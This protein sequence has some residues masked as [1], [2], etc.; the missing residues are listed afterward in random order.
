M[1]AELSI[2]EK[3]TLLALARQALEAAANGRP[4]PAP[5]AQ[6][7]PPALREPASSFVTLMRAGQLRGCIGGLTPEEPLWA[8]V[9]RHAAAAGLDDYRFGPV[10]PAEVPLIEIEVSV[11][12]P[13]QPL[14]YASPAELVSR[15]RPGVDG[16]VLMDGHRRATF[17]PQVWEHVPN[18]ETFL[19]LLCEKLGA[20][21][22][23]WRRGGLKVETYQV[24]KFTESEMKVET[25][26]GQPPARP[27]N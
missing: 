26:L 12:T 14:A 6:Q 1:P 25:G 21:P 23:R 5:D 22:Q 11:L 3:Q 8:D 13:P 16:V 20:D 15:L 9:R 2:L 19:A 4:A 18:P 27:T 17:L 10:A 24:I 7:L